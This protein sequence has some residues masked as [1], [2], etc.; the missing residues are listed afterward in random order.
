VAKNSSTTSKGGVKDLFHYLVLSMTSIFTLFNVLESKQEWK[1]EHVTNALSD[2]IDLLWMADPSSFTMYSYTSTHS[3]SLR[4]D[5]TLAEQLFSR[6]RR[7]NTV[8]SFSE[9]ILHVDHIRFIYAEI[10][11]VISDY[12]LTYS[13]ALSG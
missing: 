10:R 5:Q 4:T 13:L 12:K 3:F 11:K 9:V 1:L 6:F 8:P 2:S 7:V